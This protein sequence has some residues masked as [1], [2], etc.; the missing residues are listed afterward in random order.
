MT[1]TSDLSRFIEHARDRGLDHATIR[2]LLLSA[3][4]KEKD[5]LEALARTSLDLPIPPP[6]DR[7]GAREAFFH[8]LTFASLYATVIATV[9][10]YF[11][12]IDRLFPDP[13]L[14]KAHRGERWELTAIRWSL[15]F[16]IVAFP[17][18]L[19]LSRL[20]LREMRAHPE[21]SW[22]AVRRWLTYLTL[23]VAAIA[24]GGDVIALVFRLLEGELTVRFLLK[25]V[26]V[27]VIAGLAFAYYLLAL[28]LPADRLDRDRVQRTFG[29]TAC[30]IV[31]G[32]IAWGLWITGSPGAARL[33]KFDRRRVEDLS[34]IHEAIL[35]ITLGTRRWADGDRTME[36]PLPR[37]LEEVRDLAT[38]HRPDIR[39]PETTEPYGYEIL[40]DSTYRLCATFH[41]ERNA[42]SVP[43]W[44]HPAGRHCFELDVL[45][46]TQ[47]GIHYEGP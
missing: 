41:T 46:T 37:T 31:L 5:V 28:R 14:A 32:S 47:P 39:D 24:L 23:F 29:V 8:L 7:G 17:V 4:W 20:L 18:F 42:D 21:R 43:V 19:W 13:A 3:G 27:L 36:R 15:A 6:P 1:A 34:T 2:M 10:L 33:E 12:Y 30:A 35:D 40:S 25:V 44:N 22:S 11:H 38:Q 9:I 45:T 26:V 16:V